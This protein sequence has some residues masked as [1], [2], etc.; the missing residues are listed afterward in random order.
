MGL[1]VDKGLAER[2]ENSEIDTLSS[3]LTEMQKIDGNP[4]KVEIQKFGNAT[5]FSVKNIPGPSFNTVKGLRKGDENQ[6]GKIIDFYKQKE[7]PVRFELTPGHTS[8]ELLTHLS[9]TG[10]YHNDFH[11]T[12]YASRSNELKPSY[13]LGDQ[14]IVIRKLK[15][16]EFDTFAEIYTKGFEMPPFLK[17]GIAQNNE[18][19]YNIKNWAFYLASYEK[20]PAG[21][22]VL[23]I[24]DRIATLAA[25][26]TLPTFRK[27]GI[28]SALIKYRI[29]QAYLKKCDLIVGQAKFGSVSQ[30]NMERAGL[31]IAYTKAIWVKK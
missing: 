11:T 18:I 9:E 23:F 30:N 4:M 5:A 31:S 27:K 19:L 20:E 24:K 6:I 28:Q 3:R 22:G 26:T 17:S 1:V 12:L 10:Y 15:S 21:I 14:K 16:N 2:L 13:V 7:I 29:Y 25:A 8:P